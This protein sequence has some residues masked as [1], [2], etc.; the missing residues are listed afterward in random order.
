MKQDKVV[1]RLKRMGIVPGNDP[2]PLKITD[3]ML[4]ILSQR[5]H[6]PIEYLNRLYKLG[7]LNH[8]RALV[9]W[10]R[11]LYCQGISQRYKW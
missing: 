9:L 2:K 4:L 6:V 10:N 5:M 1:S 8:D 3:E 7:L 11:A